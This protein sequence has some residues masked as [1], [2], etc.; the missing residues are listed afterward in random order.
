M[1]NDLRWWLVGKLVGNDYCLINVEIENADLV[2]CIGKKGHM[3]NVKMD[4]CYIEF[5]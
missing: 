1:L 5:D 4:N 3:R 2:K